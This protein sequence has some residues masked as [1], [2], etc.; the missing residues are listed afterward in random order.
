MKKTYVVEKTRNEYS[1]R[2]YNE[3]LTDEDST[4]DKMIVEC[5]DIQSVETTV[6]DKNGNANV[7]KNY[8]V[9]C[10]VCG[11]SNMMPAS[12]CEICSNLFEFP[13]ENDNK[14]ERKRWKI[15]DLI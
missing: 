12:Q 13:D 5:D 8:Y 4:Y 2:I 10:A 7:A 6:T 15:S 9:V 3:I 11:H 1:K 14:K